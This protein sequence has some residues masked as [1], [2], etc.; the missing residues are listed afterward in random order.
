MSPGRTGEPRGV[1]YRGLSSIAVGIAVAVLLVAVSLGPQSS[2]GA[3]RA[4][5]APTAARS[6]MH[7]LAGGPSLATPTPQVDPQFVPNVLTSPNAITNG[8]FGSAVAAAGS[9]MVV[10]APGESVYI[11]GYPYSGLA[12]VINAQTGAETAL[13]APGAYEYNTD[14]GES[15]AIAGSAIVVGAPFSHGFEGA[16]YVFERTGA[17]WNLVA[18]LTSPNAQAES[19]LPFYHGGEFGFSVAISG[20][21]VAVGAP[22][23]NVSDSVPGAGHVYLFNLQTDLVKTLASPSPEINGSFGASVGLSG[24]RLVVGAPIEGS[25]A[26]YLY[27][28]STGDLI[29]S[30]SSPNPVLHGYQ[31]VSGVFGYSVAINGTNLAIGAP[32]EDAGPYAAAG[33]AY[34][35]NL[36]NGSVLTLNASQPSTPALFG[37]SVAIDTSTVLVGAVF[38]NTTDVPEV[39]PG[40][41]ELFS[42][43]GGNLTTS[44][45]ISSTPTP[46][47]FFGWS[48]A[49]TAS[50]VLIGAPGEN[51]SGFFAAGHAYEFTRVPLSYTSPHAIPFEFGN[52][53]YAVAVNQTVVIGA[54][55]EG[56]GGTANAGHAYVL[57]SPTGAYRTLTS[58]SPQL[59]GLFGYS[60]GVAGS[61]VVVGAA[62]ETTGGAPNSGEAYLFTTGG[63]LVATLQD[64]NAQYHGYFGY[65]V[66]IAGN[67]LVVGAPGENPGAG[68]DEGAVFVY[69]ASTGVLIRTL[70]SPDGQ[71][72]G[73]FGY[74]VALSGGEIVVGAPGENGFNG[75]AYVFSA[76]TGAELFSLSPSTLDGGVF[77]YS[78]GVGGSTIVVGAPETE[79]ASVPE[80]GVAYIFSSSNGA[81]QTMV[82]SP[83]PTTGGEFGAS[84][85]DNGGTILV[86]APEE[87][88]WGY[89][90]AGSVY[91]VN[92]SNG[93]VIDRYNSV[94]LNDEEDFGQSVA[95]GPGGLVLVGAPYIGDGSAYLF[96]L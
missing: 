3:P 91:L 88:A 12:Y 54:P 45:F 8:G 96:F 70:A 90:A 65:S 49:E 6:P 36:L 23:E 62:N 71:L 13:F 92:P 42:L 87:T 76:T 80:A 18:S 51:A 9:T 39:Q 46:G 44:P 73:F 64:P 38:L 50:I 27:A 5:R 2:P 20:N 32:A 72:D 74:S 30:F 83:S 58:P 57:T 94:N 82:G 1:R 31:G 93:A 14:F 7:L 60:V 61:H 67:L 26:A 29:Q 37:Y 22:D 59:V 78:V 79:F 77:G 16:A 48:V 52:F 75:S 19:Y 85:A 11:E 56:V 53:G 33:H 41:A 63:S 43:L 40:G 81:L 10:G 21:W 86:G 89:F 55:Y 95:I 24:N 17:A 15:V 66:A 84:V 34:V 69:S 25:G 28:A 35:Y 4:G 68:P 47:G